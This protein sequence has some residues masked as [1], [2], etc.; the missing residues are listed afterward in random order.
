MS[1]ISYWFDFIFIKMRVIFTVVLLLSSLF[2]SSQ[3]NFVSIDTVSSVCKVNLNLEY[4]KKFESIN[5]SISSL[6]SAQK[7]ITKEI[8]GEI[9]NNFLEKISSNNFICDDKINPYLQ[10]LMEEVLAKNSISKE[11][12]RMLLSRNSEINAYNTGDGTIVVNYGLF[13]ATDTEDELVFVISHEIGHQYLNHIKNDIEAF[14]KLTT[15]EEIVQKTKEIRR[16]KYGKATMATDLLKNIVYQNYDERRKNEIEA[17]S[18]GF[19]LYKKTLRNP[20]AAITLLE[21]FDN[22]DKEKDSLTLADY[23]R[24]FERDGFVLKQKYFEEE[25]SLF[26]KYD[27]EK[28]INVDSLKTHPDCITRVKLIKDHLDNK[29]TEQYSNSSSFSEIKK[30]STYQN[31]LNLFSSEKFGMSLYEALKLYKND[32]ENA[33]LKNIIYLN[34]TKI[35]ASKANYTINRYVPAHDNLHNTA[36]M[37]R[38]IS[39]L[40]N[41]KM[42]DM[43]TIINNFKS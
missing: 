5:K 4:K 9:Q 30:N 35:Y 18:V 6:S 16:Q 38:F 25:Q 20:K 33:I 17:D 3:L 29:F 42:T 27:K 7:G 40:N 2:A 21:K 26:K 39:F 37:N 31:L 34:L 1:D 28:R 36:S 32:S 19:L 41:I 43:E 15:S 23:K 13:L 10:G 22:S 12:Y 24:I 8:Y 11:G 14:A